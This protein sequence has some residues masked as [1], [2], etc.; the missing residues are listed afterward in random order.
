MSDH[1]E[2][3][4][5]P[6]DLVDL[7]L[8]ANDDGPRLIAW[9]P[10]LFDTLSEDLGGFRERIGRRAFDLRADHFEV[11]RAWGQAPR[12]E[13]DRRESRKGQKGEDLYDEKLW[14]N[15]QSVAPCFQLRENRSFTEW[16]ERRYTSDTLTNHNITD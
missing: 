4:A 6:L 2:R 3:R 15:P 13:A 16:A 9:Y 7:E 10:A 8:R 5:F 12:Q 14:G 11:D 1:L